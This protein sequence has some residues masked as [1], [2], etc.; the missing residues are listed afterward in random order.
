MV[1]MI[2]GMADNNDKKKKSDGNDKSSNKTCEPLPQEQPQKNKSSSEE[3]KLA[4]IMG[5]VSST[6]IFKR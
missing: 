4:C 5:Q 2:G 6:I 3:G 1:W